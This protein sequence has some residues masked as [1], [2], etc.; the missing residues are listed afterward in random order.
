MRREKIDF[1]LIELL[2]AIAI[3]AIL[4]AMLL[5]VLN[6][7]REKARGTDCVNRLKQQGTAVAMYMTDYKGFLPGTMVGNLAYDNRATAWCNP[8]IYAM[9]T[10]AGLKYTYVSSWGSNP[11]NL[12]QCPSDDKGYE[13]DP[14]HVHSYFSSYY[15]NWRD[16]S[17]P[18]LRPEKMR[19]PS[20][21][22][23]VIDCFTTA[24]KSLT[25]NCYPLNVSS[26]QDDGYV[27][28]RHSNGANALFMDMHVSAMSFKELF[29]SGAK[30]V[31]SKTP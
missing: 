9:I 30:Y 25:V 23:Y 27:A 29:G 10:Y 18:M 28:T 15:S 26:S 1:T 19:T 7:A 8:Y 11:G 17:Q 6:R 24:P 2:T 13:K 16:L 21:W 31:Y 3:I 4:A 12:M 14:R 5:P 20:K 22:I